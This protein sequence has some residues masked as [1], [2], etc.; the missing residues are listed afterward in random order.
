[1]VWSIWPQRLTGERL[2]SV[3][4]Q[5]SRFRLLIN[6]NVHCQP[7]TL[8]KMRKNGAT[9]NEVAKPITA[10]N[11][12]IAL[13]MQSTRS[14]GRV[15]EVASL[16]DFIHYAPFRTNSC[17]IFGLVCTRLLIDASE[18]RASCAS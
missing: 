3:D 12:A 17:D 2:C 14:A 9:T 1:M 18:A 10:T 7:R 11:L 16:R 15:A 8:K 5:T 13:Y 4:V 6:C